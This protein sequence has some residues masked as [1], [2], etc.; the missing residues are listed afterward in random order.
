MYLKSNIKIQFSHLKSKNFYSSDNKTTSSTFFPIISYSNAELQKCKIIKDNKKKSGVYRWTNLINKK[1][2]IGSS[3][4]L[5]MRFKHYYSYSYISSVKRNV[6]IHAALLK[7]GYSK[8]KLD[9]LE[10]CDK[11][12]LIGLEQFYLNLLKPEYNILTIT[13]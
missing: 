2:Y 6:P 9:I 13:V 7:Y 3:I 5:S 12:K 4:D 8:F 10:Y 1:T 11:C